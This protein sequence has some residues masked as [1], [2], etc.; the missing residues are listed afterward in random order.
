M[1]VTGFGLGLLA[2]ALTVAAGGCAAERT[3]VGSGTRS[4]APDE[5]AP[6]ISQQAEP[7]PQPSLAAAM[8]EWEAVAGDHFKD[9]ARA[10]EKVSAAAGVGDDSAV[11]A[12][13]TDLHDTNIVG[14]QGHLPTPDPA[15]TAELQRMID[16]VNIATHACLRFAD[17]RDLAEAVTYQEYL[18]RAV[19]H[20]QRAK[21]ILAADLRGR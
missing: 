21:G 5:P 13:C 3:V 2:V 14:L 16:D 12:G 11:R 19:E 18:G 6:A 4:S 8:R 7:S 20:L 17:G 15:L 10:L 9:S 1:G